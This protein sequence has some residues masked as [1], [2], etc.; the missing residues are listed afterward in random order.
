[1]NNFSKSV[2]T[3]S[4][5]TVF[6]I[7]TPLTTYASVADANESSAP[8]MEQQEQTNLG[9]ENIMAVSWYQ[10]SAEAKA[11]YLQGYNSAKVQ[12]DKE[13]KKNKGK[14]KLAIALDLDETVLD[15]SPYQGYA[16]I[17]NT[18]YPEGW[19]E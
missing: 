7:G 15:N 1:M 19:H 12:L 13:L 16:S 3:V 17:N 10:N 5:A 2:I 8:V 9:S 4:L 18:S 6:T 14:H 11:L